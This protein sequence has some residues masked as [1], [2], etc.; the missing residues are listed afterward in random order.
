MSSSVTDEVWLTYRGRALHL[1][2]YETPG[3]PVAVFVHPFASTAASCAPFCDA[4][5]AGGFTVLALDLQGHGLSEGRRGHL[6]FRDGLANVAEAVGFAAE[7]FRTP[8]GLIGSGLGGMLAL[9]A[10]LEDERVRAVVASG[11]ADLRTI[12]GAAGTR[13]SRA[14]LA[15]APLLRSLARVVPTAKIPAGVIASPADMFDDPEAAARWRA[16]D[17]APRSYSLEMVVSFFL[18]PDSKPALEALEKPAL[19]VAGSEDRAIPFVVQRDVAACLPDAELTVLGGAG[20]MLAVEYA[21]E[22]A[23]RAGEWLSKRI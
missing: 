23:R 17:R 6:P 9:Y 10:A 19:I 20:H 13:R 12:A 18:E 4:V 14:M 16:L 21:D 1:D 5:R 7:R 22:F 11:V 15:C 8:V 2:V 3:A